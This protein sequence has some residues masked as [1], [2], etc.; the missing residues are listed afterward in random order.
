LRQLLIHRYK[1]VRIRAQVK[2]GSQHLDTIGKAN[3]FGPEPEALSSA[4][5]RRGSSSG[6]R[7]RASVQTRR[8]GALPS[9]SYSPYSKRRG[10]GRNCCRGLPAERRG[11][12]ALLYTDSPTRM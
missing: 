2:N 11:R 12:G 6:G 1:L 5:S 4:R 3:S 8:R 10:C 7:G 9:V